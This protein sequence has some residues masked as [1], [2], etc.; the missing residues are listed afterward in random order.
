[1]RLSYVLI[2]FKKNNMQKFGLLMVVVLVGAIGCTQ[3]FKKSGKGI[4]YKIISDG[5]G[6]KLQYG[7]F[8]QFHGLS[9]VFKGAAPKSIK[10]ED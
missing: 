7:D 4:E 3:P 2:I 5:K 6:Q 10:M 9:P 1:M 8:M